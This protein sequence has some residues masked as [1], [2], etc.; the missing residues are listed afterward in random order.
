MEKGRLKSIGVLVGQ[1]YREY[2]VV[3]LIPQASHVEI[4]HQRI[5]VE[6]IVRKS[7]NAVLAQTEHVQSV[8]SQIGYVAIRILAIACINVDGDA[9]HTI[10]P[11]DNTFGNLKT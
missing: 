1:C 8:L 4:A 3:P 2:T 9:G 6:I 11:F 10:A 5:E 7:P